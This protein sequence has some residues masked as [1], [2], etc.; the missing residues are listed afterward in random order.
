M[1]TAP[2]HLEFAPPPTPGF[3]R[4]LGLA[5]LASLAASRTGASHLEAHAAL[6]AGYHAA[7]LAG[8][9]VALAA[10]LLGLLLRPGP[11]REDVAG[12]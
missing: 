5:I 6:N 4:A 11:L 3:L 7:F 9:G 10:A 12:H 8:A 2:R 1:S